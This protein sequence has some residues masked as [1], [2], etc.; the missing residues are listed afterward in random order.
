M[1]INKPVAMI[2]IY[3][4]LIKEGAKTIEEVPEIIRED[5]AQALLD[6]SNN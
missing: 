1:S 2:R 5:V 4:D 3:S 6:S